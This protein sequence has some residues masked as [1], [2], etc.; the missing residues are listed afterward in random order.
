MLSISRSIAASTG[1]L[2]N[3]KA[4]IA[5]AVTAALPASQAHAWS[6]T[7]VTNWDLVDYEVRE[8]GNGYTIGSTGDGAA[9]Y[10]WS[11]S[12]SKSTRISGNS[13]GDGSLYGL[14]DIAANDTSYHRLFGG[15]TGL[16]FLLRGRTTQSGGM[17]NH[18]GVLRR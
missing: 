13:C 2:R 18:D 8:Y 15:F 9:Y 5:A 17:Y 16:C 6:Y 1:L 4:C 10:R 12:P 3:P 11:D 7:T 14:D